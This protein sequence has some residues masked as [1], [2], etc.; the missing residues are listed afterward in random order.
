MSV[1][2]GF[3]FQYYNEIFEARCTDEEKPSN[4]VDSDFQPPYYPP[5]FYVRT[6]EI[7]R[8]LLGRAA[9]TDT[10]L[11]FPDGISYMVL[12]V[13]YGGLSTVTTTR[14]ASNNGGSS[15][16]NTTG[17]PSWPS[18]F[19]VFLTETEIV[20][21]TVKTVTY[22]YTDEEDVEQT[23]VVTHTLS[24]V[25]DIGTVEANVEAAL[26]AVS[27][28]SWTFGTPEI[29]CDRNPPSGL[30]YLGFNFRRY[31]KISQFKVCAIPPASC[32][33]NYKIKG[34][35]SETASFPLEIISEPE[36]AGTPWNA[37]P[38][39]TGTPEDNLVDVIYTEEPPYEIPVYVTVL[40]PDEIELQGQTLTSSLI[41]VGY[42]TNNGQNGSLSII[43]VSCVKDW[44]PSEEDGDM[45]YPPFQ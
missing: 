17:S 42:G 3:P 36:T 10:G 28:S 41:S 39:F 25:Y 2:H 22:H 45:P 40:D 15:S 16:D 24:S 31:K 33:L 29:I 11:N 13:D 21:D 14:T 23:F 35:V 4:T 37:Q 5:Y 44:M 19:F 26:T 34:I 12:T 43:R 38:T 7:T 6:K 8:N 32:Y 1:Y 27:W 18:N 30:S 20:S 9:W